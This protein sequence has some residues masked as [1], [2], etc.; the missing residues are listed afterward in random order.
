M[1]ITGRI[2]VPASMS[3]L[4]RQ[5]LACATLIISCA[6]FAE[7]GPPYITDD[8]EPVD[9]HHWEIFLATILHRYHGER[10]GE[11]PEVEVNYGALQNFE[12]HIM[13]PRAW[14]DSEHEPKHYGIGDTEVGAEWRFVQETDSRPQVS[15]YPTLEIPTGD[16]RNGL[17]TGHPQLFLP[18]WAEKNYGKWTAYGGG[19]YWINPGRGN[20]NYWYTGYV[21]ERQITNSWNLGAEIYHSTSAASG[22]C[23]QSGYNVGTICEVSEHLHLMASAGHTFTGSALFTGYA[24]VQITF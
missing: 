17:G 19:G 11:A 12:L 21:V 5:A 6:P 23:G 24:S 3:S 1:R 14:D 15:T 16:S 4:M 8:P 13:I 22:A 7:S 20:R 2:K 18:L 10:T 9:L